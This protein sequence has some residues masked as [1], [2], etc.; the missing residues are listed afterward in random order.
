M[1]NPMKKLLRGVGLPIVLVLLL[2]G[3]TAILSSP[4]KEWSEKKVLI[5]EGTTLE[6]AARILH[7]EGLI[8]QEWIFRILGKLTL[9]EKKI[10]AGEYILNT[11]MS[12]VDVL[13]LFREGKIL[14]HHVVVRQG[15]TLH[16]IGRT[17]DA[18]GLMDLGTFDEW[19]HDS[20]FIASLGL[21]G[22]SLEGYLYP[23]TYFFF[24]GQ[25]VES[26]LRKMVDRFQEHISPELAHRADAMGMSLLEVVTLAS[27]IETEAVVPSDRPLI[28]AV[29]HN[30]LRKGIP[31]QSD[32]TVIYALGDQF[33]GDLKRV[34]LRMNSPFNTYIN[35]GLPPGPIG[36][37]ALPS[38]RAALYPAD[39]DYYYFVSRNN[40]T[41]QFSKTIR[42]HNQ[43][44]AVYQKL[45]KG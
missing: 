40:G 19:T 38:L 30:R 25:S 17:L 10:Q 39:V 7:G 2:G 43:A 22:E 4:T 33:N 8:S 3:F 9:S 29:F 37:P 5:P 28:S 26:I 41:H 20:V 45:K 21:Q 24:K 1:R 32:P 31:L 44:V 11:Q 23:D 13:R 12:S 14:T 18:E 6:G 36:S 27:I 35:K 42:D 16:G 34:H 15:E